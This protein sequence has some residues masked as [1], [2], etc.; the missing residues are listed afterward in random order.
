MRDQFD[1]LPH[2]KQRELAHVTRALFKEFEAM[3]RGGS[4]AYTRCA[5]TQAGHP[6]MLDH[7]AEQ[8]SVMRDAFSSTAVQL[9]ASYHGGGL[10]S[11]GSRD[12]PG[13]IP[14]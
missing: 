3:H 1:H 9:N 13:P 10:K 11:G 8:R 14:C 4:R 12:G 2:T 6:L 5:R 7:A